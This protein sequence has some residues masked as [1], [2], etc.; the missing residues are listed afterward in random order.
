MSNRLRTITIDSPALGREQSVNFY[1]PTSAHPNKNW[2][3]LF[4]MHGMGG[5]H[6]RWAA[7]C[8]L[9]ELTQDYPVLLVMPSCENSFYLDSPLG[10]MEWF[11][12]KDLIGYIDSNFP[13]DPSPKSRALTGYSMGGYGAL[14]LALR[15]P[16]L[17]CSAASHS[18]A[19]LTARAT[20]EAGVKWELADTLYGLGTEGELKRSD[21]DILTLTQ[22]FLRTDNETGLAKY[23]GPKLYLDC[24]TEDFLYYASR[25]L[26]QA[27][28]MLH[29]PYE[30]HESV[31]G[32]DWD[33]WSDAAKRSVEFHLK[34]LL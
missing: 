22:R 12:C 15:N 25:E 7:N 1:L 11:I 26:T 16:D 14:L 3:T 5:D 2:K 23:T 20:H 27:L 32:H 21:H 19:V 9:E 34:Q 10:N 6:T 4:L 29:I 33:Y 30:Y 18:G 28:R 13:T 8:D 31:G 24:G 17:F